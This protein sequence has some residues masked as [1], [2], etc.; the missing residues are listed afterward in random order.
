MIVFLLITASYKKAK[1]HPY[2]FLTDWW[3]WRRPQIFTKKI[4]SEHGNISNSKQFKDS[5]IWG[6]LLEAVIKW[7]YKNDINQHMQE[8]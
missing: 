8:Q 6:Q 2:Y 3:L 1:F 5:G 7:T 4:P